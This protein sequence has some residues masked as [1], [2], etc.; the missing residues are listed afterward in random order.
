[1]DWAKTTAR[2]DKNHLSFGIWCTLYQRFDSNINPIPLSPPS[3][4]VHPVPYGHV[5]PCPLPRWRPL[6]GPLRTA[7][8]P[9]RISRSSVSAPSPTTWP[10]ISLTWS[11]TCPCVMVVHVPPQHL[12]PRVTALDVWPLTTQCH[13]SRMS[14]A[15]NSS[16]RWGDSDMKWIKQYGWHT[17]RLQ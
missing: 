7:T 3:L 1:M 15:S 12:W 11:S 16:L 2:Q 4:H 8:T 17:T 14:N 10:R 9:R 13:W 5:C 6:S